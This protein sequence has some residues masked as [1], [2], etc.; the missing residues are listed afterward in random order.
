IVRPFNCIGAGQ[1]VR[2]LAPKIVDAFRTRAD[3][4]VIGNLAVER[5]FLD[6]RDFAQMLALLVFNGA[7]HRV[8]NFC[9]G[10][11]VSIQTLI[12][13]AAR[14][15]GHRLS[16]RSDAQFQRPNDLT[17]QL[18]DNARIREAGYIRRYSIDDTIGW[19]LSA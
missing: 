18:G 14:L 8:L 3:E 7:S 17:R 10:E 2:F 13:A 9:N 15:S 12:D 16:V 11:T 5:D 1:P 19:M 4:L 6:A